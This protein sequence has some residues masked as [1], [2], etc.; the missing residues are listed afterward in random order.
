MADFDWEAGLL[1][2]YRCADIFRAVQSVPRGATGPT[3]LAVLVETGGYRFLA[4]AFDI[5][6]PSNNDIGAKLGDERNRLAAEDPSR[7][8]VL[9]WW[10]MAGRPTLDYTGLVITIFGEQLVPSSLHVALATLKELDGQ[11]SIASY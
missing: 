3:A 4:A 1:L 11:P 6:Q 7:P 10:H 2:T 5:G 8:P 9:L